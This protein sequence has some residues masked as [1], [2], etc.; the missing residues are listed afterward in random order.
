MNGTL[1]ETMGTAYTGNGLTHKYESL[2]QQ[3][4]TTI[5]IKSPPTLALSAVLNEIAAL[6]LT[7]GFDV[8]RF[9]SPLHLEK[10]DGIYVKGPEL[11]YVLAS[12]PIPLEPTDLGGKHRVISFYDVYDEAKL[13]ANNP[14]I[15]ENI[16]AAATYVEKALATLAEAKAIH[17]EWEAVNIRRMDWQAHELQTERLIQQVFHSLDVRKTS[18]VTHR[19]MGSL[20]VKGAHDFIPSITKA[21]KRRILIKSLPGTGKSTMMRALGEEAEKRGIDVLYGWCG[22]DADSIDLIQFPELSVCLID[23]TDPHAYDI[24]REGDEILNL[25]NLCASDEQAELKIDDIRVRYKETIR[26]AAG[27][28]QSYAKVSSQIDVSMDSALDQKAFYEKAQ[29]LKELLHV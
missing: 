25:I 12:D 21:I 14:L 8:D 3:A 13:R 1:T 19:I 11:F 28:L 16:E 2:I 5:F 6:Y 10:T 9:R 24:E 17:D 18:L 26:N 23:A 27:Y 29:V 20:S 15:A 4:D 22:L 7:R